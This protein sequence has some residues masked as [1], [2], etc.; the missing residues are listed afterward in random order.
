MVEYLTDVIPSGD[1]WFRVHAASLDKL[2]MPVLFNLRQPESSVS[3]ARWQYVK[4]TPFRKTIETIGSLLADVTSI[5]LIGQTCFS[6]NQNS[7]KQKVL[8]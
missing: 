8:V 5:G 4:N 6:T 2:E 7:K 1:A 3:D